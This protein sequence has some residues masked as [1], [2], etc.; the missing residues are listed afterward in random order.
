[1]FN[2]FSRLLFLFILTI[3][4][5]FFNAYCASRAVYSKQFEQII[6]TDSLYNKFTLE[7]FTEA[8]LD[9][10]GLN[11]VVFQKAVTGF[12]NLQS[13]GLASMS[14]IITIIDF[15]KE[16]CSK[17]FYLIDLNQK[18]LLLNTW[19]AHGINSGGNRPDHFSNV[20]NSNE[21]SVGFYLTAEVY[22]GKHGRSMRLDGLDE[23]FNDNARSRAI[24]LH[25][26]DYVC[27]ETI[28]EMGRLGRSYGCP[29][30]PAC[31]SDS[32]IDAT[33]NKSVIFI[34]HSDDDYC[35]NYL[36]VKNASRVA[37][38]KANYLASN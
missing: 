5:N 20:T 31:F 3:P 7:I 22:F 15:D 19:V 35:S 2:F 32:I 12:Y 13:D 23:G 1:M 28:D 18:K 6:S 24:V 14:N 8:K 11:P 36:D 21:S 34:N 10:A 16:S 25:G 29:A 17:R 9:S 4:F 33:A 37:L 38:Q 26:A 30:V 27:Q